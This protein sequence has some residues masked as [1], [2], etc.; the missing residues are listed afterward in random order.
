VATVFFDKSGGDAHI[1][2]NA[3]A[4]GPTLAELRKVPRRFC[5]VSGRGKLEAVRG[6]LNGKLITELVIDEGT[7]LALLDGERILDIVKSPTTSV[8]TPLARGPSREDAAGRLFANL[9]PV[10]RAWAVDRVTL[11]PDLTGGQRPQAIV[12]AHVWQA[13]QSL[14]DW[15]LVGC[16]VAPGFEFEGFE[17]APQG[18]APPGA[19]P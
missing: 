12:P 1:E 9:D 16:T 15:T 8:D 6:A 4:T 13:A 7:A 11:G 10:T 3:R 5:V 19:A 17:L 14:G 18:W 2:I